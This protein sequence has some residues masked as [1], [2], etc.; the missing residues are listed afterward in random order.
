MVYVSTDYV[1]D[2]AQARALRRVGRRPDRCQELRPLEA[3]RRARHRRGQ[4]RPP[5]RAQLVAV[6]R[7]AGAT[8]SR[9]CFAWVMSATSCAWSTTRSGCPTFTG[10]LAEALR[11]AGSRASERG[12]HHLAGGGSCSWFEFAR[13]IFDRAGVDCRVE[14]C[15]TDGVSAA[16]HAAGVLRAGQRA[17]RA[18]AAR[19]AG[20]SATTYLAGG[21]R[22]R[23]LVTGA[24]GFIGSTYVRLRRRGP[25]RGRARQA[26][27][28]R[29][30]REPPRRTSSWS[31]AGSRTA[32]SCMRG[33]RGRRRDRELR[34]RVARR[35]LDRRPGRLRPHPRD[36]HR[37][38]CSTRRASA[39]SARYLQV[40][41]D[42]VYGSIAGGL[43]HRDLAARPVVALLGHQGR[44][45]PAGLGARPH[46]RDR[47]GDLPRLEQLRPAPV[48]READPA[49][50][51]ERA[52]RRPAAGL[53]RRPPGA[54]LALR[55][56]LL[57]RR[58]TRV[59]ERGR[60]GEAYNVGG[61]DECE[62]IEVVR[63]IL[64]LTGRD[65]SLIE[66]VTRPARPRPP[67]LALLAT[68]CARSSAG[69][70][71]VRSR[72]A[73]RG[74]STGTATTRRGGRR[75]APASTASTTSGTYGQAP[76]ASQRSLASKG[77]P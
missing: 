37:A 54:Q 59:L 38:C 69:R 56:G 36:R 76:W 19:L 53:R 20:R 14:P 68:S 52:A 74:R 63:R 47:G 40:S 66:Y 1:F 49:V 5:H 41:T 27:L 10:H 17:R 77:V 29:P 58:S 48:P 22:V 25:R 15:T 75:S 11:R 7:R 18:R 73:W 35:P 12:I 71:Q 33:H 6:R 44:R 46:L 61:P 8:S 13:E 31:W 28:R 23:L 72:R 32:T 24:A 30:A 55:R 45:R 4:P 64:E 60:P 21:A 42:E 57:P 26:H 9:R 16:R 50:R 34:G 2:G 39:A 62:N 67:L 43:V 70:P 65:E 51:P 3:R